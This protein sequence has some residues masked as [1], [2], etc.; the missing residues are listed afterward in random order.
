MDKEFES[1][2]ESVGNN[3]HT[4]QFIIEDVPYRTMD[5]EE[6]SNHME[7]QN[8]QEWRTQPPRRTPKW[9][10]VLITLF[11]AILIGGV[12]GSAAF[13]I[14][15]GSTSST[16]STDENKLPANDSV[17]N[18][19]NTAIK[20]ES[21]NVIPTDNSNNIVVNVAKDVMPSIVSI[22]SVVQTQDY[23]GSIQDG[24]SS[25]SG[26][27]Y[28][29]TENELL[30]VTN[31]HVISN[32]KKI[33]VT[34]CDDQEVEATV[35]GTDSIADLAVIAIPLSSIKEETMSSI[36]VITLGKSENVQ[37][38]EMAIAIGNALGYGQSVTVGYISAKDRSISQDDVS[39]TLLQTDAA[40]NPG[41]SGGALLNGAGE[42]IGINSIKFAS[43]SV[44][45]MGYAIPITKAIPIIDDLMTREVL[46][47]EEKGYLGVSVTNITQE[48]S[49]RYNMPIGV[50]VSS[51][52]EEGAAS[53]A[54]ILPNDII[55][56][57]NGIEVIDKTA[58]AER[59][60]SYRKGTVIKVT[61]QRRN[62]GEY[63]EMQIDVTL[64]GTESMTSLQGSSNNSSND[65][66]SNDNNNNNSGNSNQQQD[67]FFNNFPWSYFK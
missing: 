47:A 17:K 59:V 14:K 15:T 20:I 5:Q 21:T 35:K 58:L 13:F 40:I 57:I 48:E 6:P 33:T 3:S 26:I 18:P 52:A 51:L 25:G 23:F 65:N 43:D 24:A 37:V 36:K 1:N 63:Q 34:F 54:G 2:N 39:M 42:L 64:K 66:S 9:A 67:D 50:Y 38:G 19:S 49:T 55:T 27:I 4:E 30:I 7:Y 10:K 41:N 45:G 29:Q 16:S 28:K 12:I 56:A 53:E 44:E 60:N 22:I 8:S 32:A 31:N 62:D 46:T 11:V 61:L